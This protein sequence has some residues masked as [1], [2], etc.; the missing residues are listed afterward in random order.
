VIFINMTQ[1]NK[2]IKT[3]LLEQLGAT[4]KAGPADP[5]A[6]TGPFN[7][8]TIA[9]QIYDAKGTLSDAE[10]KVAPAFAAI[11]NISQY[12]QVNKALQK[13]TGNRGIGEY[14]ISFMDIN[15]R[16]A[17]AGRLMDIL[18]ASQ[19]DWTIKKLVPWSD[20][21]TV[22][23]K[24]PSL[25]A[26]WKAGETGIGEEK[27]LLKLMRGPYAKE[28]KVESNPKGDQL[29]AWWKENGH[30][31]LLTTQIITAFIP[32]V[33][34][35]ISAGI[36]IGNATMY[37]NEGDPKSAGMEAVFSVIPGLGLAGKLGLNK[38]APKFMAAL[39]KKL[40]SGAT[41]TLT[42]QEQEILSLLGKNQKALKKELDYYFRSGI[43]KS[44]KQV[45]KAKLGAA[46]K[47]L[48]AGTAKLGAGLGTY[49]AIQNL[50]N[51][52]YDANIELISDKE[53]AAL[54][55]QVDVEFTKWLATKKLTK[56]ADG[57]IPKT[58]SL[59]EAIPWAE[60]ITGAGIGGGLLASKT[61]GPM[62]A[63]LTKKYKTGR[64]KRL[65]RKTLV[66]ELGLKTKQQ[67]KAMY[68][69]GAVLKAQ[70]RIFGDVERQLTRGAITPDIA[71]RKL[72]FIE[73]P[74][75]TKDLY[76]SFKISY[77]AVAEKIRKTGK[78]P[79][80]TDGKLDPAD[81]NPLAPNNT[82]LDASELDFKKWKEMDDK[83]K[84]F[85]RNV[86]DA[87]DDVFGK[88]VA[89]GVVGGV[90][91]ASA[92]GLGIS[93]YRDD[94][95]NLINAW[96][97][98]LAA[99]P[100]TPVQFKDKKVGTKIPLYYYDNGSY[101]KYDNLYYTIPKV[102]PTISKVKVSNDKKYTMVL[103][104]SGNYRWVATKSLTSATTKEPVVTKE[105][106]ATEP[107]IDKTK[108]IPIAPEDAVADTTTYIPKEMR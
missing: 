6:I 89:R 33:G 46:A 78:A 19:W 45:T 67:V 92:V 44:A 23:A 82:K 77:E 87:A 107:V 7:A 60:L 76:N 41:K 104:P 96:K 52:A 43:A 22:A 4:M 97:S 69:S 66:D 36:G 84:K 32:V 37:Y 47:K 108:D 40:A 58:G 15:P 25:Y 102:A 24:Q 28:W 18:P 11:K 68:I 8:Q 55:K 70:Q 63:W 14:L 16:L 62:I 98:K 35:A 17:I 31:I 106:V 27:A 93:K 10:E 88:K 1:L 20:F 105:P 54:N 26:K 81:W 73:N 71:M 83:W 95:Y 21:K 51:T 42:K 13:L 65:D 30:N 48:T 50:Y 39:G 100:K 56:I 103:L 5:N 34:W 29:N 99:L 101:A 59:T 2:I 57:V 91:A 72:T 86:S 53:L 90:A 80:M 79:S 3:V 9:K 64:L 38:Y 94:K 75:L 12:A 61:A 74:G 85:S 49:T